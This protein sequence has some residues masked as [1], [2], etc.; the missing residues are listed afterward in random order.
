MVKSSNNMMIKMNKTILMNN[1]P[2]HTTKQ[3]PILLKL[4]PKHTQLPETKELTLRV[5][6]V[7]KSPTPQVAMV[8][9]TQEVTLKWEPVE[10]TVK[11][12]LLITKLPLPPLKD[13]VKVEI[14]DMEKEDNLDTER[15]DNP[16]T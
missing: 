10:D 15:E 6:K 8:K 3:T 13:M 5:V 7:T 4:K 1:K 11:V 9:A 16:V 12:K 2:H 14:L